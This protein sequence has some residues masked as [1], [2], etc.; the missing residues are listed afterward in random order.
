MP[1]RP[2]SR[3]VYPALVFIPLFYLLVRYFPTS[4]FFALVTAAALFALLEL[5]R[6]HFRDEPNR[7]ATGLGLGLT[8]LLLASLQWPTLVSERTVVLLTVIAVLLSRLLA[9]R[10]MKHGLVDAAVLVFGVLYIGLAMG[11]LLLTRALAGGEFLIFFLVVV[12]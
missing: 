5:Y 7:I 10:E 9:T 6:L 12:T 4:A 2:D 8:G 3:R 1:R 11:H